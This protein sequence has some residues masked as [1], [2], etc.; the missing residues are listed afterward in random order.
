MNEIT[1]FFPLRTFGWE[2][3]YRWTKERNFL[4]AKACLTNPE[5]WDK[6]NIKRKEPL[7]LSDTHF[8]WIFS[9]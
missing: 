4:G 1:V 2:K 3:A 8:A 7:R 6:E 9:F 5:H